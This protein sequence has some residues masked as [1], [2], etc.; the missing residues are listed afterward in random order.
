MTGNF[1]D[2]E[3]R[4]G[5]HSEYYINPD[6]RKHE[7]SCASGTMPL[8]GHAKY[9]AY[10]GCI[11]SLADDGK[12]II[13][14]NPKEKASCSIRIDIKESCEYIAVNRQGYFLYNEQVVI[15]VGFDG[16]II[17][18]YK[19][20]KKGNKECIYIYD[21]VVFYTVT[22][23]TGIRSEINYV[24]M[25]TKQ[26]GTVW[27][28]E[29][30]DHMFDKVFGFA[31]VEEW[32][33]DLPFSAS[34]SNI[35]NVTCEF[36]YV[37]LRRILAGYRRSKGDKTISYI[38][39]ID[40]QTQTWGILDC[41]AEVWKSGIEQ[42]DGNKHIL[43]F[44]MLDDTMYVTSDD[45][46]IQ[47]MHLSI[48]KVA[49][50]QGKYP[51]EQK[52]ARLQ[53][54]A[55]YYFFNGE[56]AYMPGSLSLFSLENGEC[57]KV[58][59]HQYQ[60]IDFWCF[61][62]IYIIPNEHSSIV[63]KG[64]WNYEINRWDVEKL[65]DC[66]KSLQTRQEPAGL[67]GGKK[68]TIV[69]QGIKEMKT[70][71][72]HSDNISLAKFRQNAPQAVGFRDVLLAFRKSL[73]NSWDYNAYVGILLGV[74]GPKHGDAACMNYAIGQGD[75]GNNTKKTLEAKGLMPIYEKYKGKKLDAAIMLSDVE[76]EI[77]AIAPEYTQIRQAFHGITGV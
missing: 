16:K 57:K 73:P 55:G 1:I 74:G 72:S 39:N 67:G 60:T 27:Y 77:I 51:I 52:F 29:K 18:S 31:Y 10:K 58:D 43:S 3:E 64:K 34:V 19:Y 41:S 28:T 32:G 62:D 48:Q 49:Q 17:H 25:V 35:G 7:F 46:D 11:Y 59:Y 30:G 22:T 15:L 33:T 23:S 76:D 4:F 24:D 53:S 26:T 45:R 63:M 75:N 68:E 40:L 56:K 47:L 38:I 44:N 70:S 61:D 37:N 9:S 8:K 69:P 36:L 65:I 21:S 6:W 42:G 50:L 20:G 5:F 71:G 2:N 13:Q 66:A 54:D 12:V 14:C